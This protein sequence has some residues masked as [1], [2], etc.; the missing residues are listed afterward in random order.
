[1]T[2]K[3]ILRVENMSKS[4]GPF[5]ALDDVTLTIYEGEIVGL[6]GDNGAGKS[7]LVKIIM[8]V[9]KP[10]AGKIYFEGKQIDTETHSPLQA[11]SLGIEPVYQ[12]RAIAPNRSVRENVFMG[13]EIVSGRFLDIPKMNQETMRGISELGLTRLTSPGKKV[14]L[15]SGGEQQAVALSR[16]LLFKS[17]LLLLDEPT[18]GVSHKM[19]TTILNPV[20]EKLS[21]ESVS[22][23]YI[24]HE[25]ERLHKLVSRVVILKAGRKISDTEKT[26][27]TVSQIVALL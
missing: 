25:L 8:G 24:T 11:L 16:A 2:G 14:M 5:K 7:T 20:F 13:R 18:T 26:N 3:E 21:S 23:L 12:E 10:D 27:I 1:M 6:V 19:A 17:K 15:L 9:Y 4:F 22:I